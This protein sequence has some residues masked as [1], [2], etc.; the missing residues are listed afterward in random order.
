MTIVNNVNWVGNYFYGLSGDEYM[1]NLDFITLR[2]TNNFDLHIRYGF[3]GANGYQVVTTDPIIV[4]A[5][6]DWDIYENQFA[7][8]STPGLYNL[9]IITDTGTLPYL[10]VM[11]NV[12][13]L[14]E[15]VVEVKIFHNPVISFDGEVVTGTLDIDL[16]E[17]QLLLSN[18]DQNESE[19]AVFP[20]PAMNLI[21][22]RTKDDRSGTVTIYNIL[23]EKVKE[24]IITSNLSQI[25]ISNF[26]SGIY[27]VTI[28]TENT[29]TTKKIVKF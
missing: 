1:I 18:E 22:I 2:N 29:S 4:P 17:A 19:A 20:N 26:T 3:T 12:H 23:G 13:D 14:F 6:S 8:T 10:E 11:N 15:E 27:L 5:L 16:I 28:K 25:D 9:T 7:V 24:L 21:S